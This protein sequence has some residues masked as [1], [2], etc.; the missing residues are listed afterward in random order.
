[1]NEIHLRVKNNLQIIVS[2]FR[3]QKNELHSDESRDQFQEAIN[4]VLVIYSIHQKLYEQDN[5]INVN[6][7]QYL[8]EL[9][10][11][12]KILFKNQQQID[13]S[14]ASD[15]PYVGLKLCFL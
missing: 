1:L 14:A 10:G 7:K 5:L 13:I 8:E 2:L 11:E 9:I 12:L 4:R 6:L 3:L 15:F